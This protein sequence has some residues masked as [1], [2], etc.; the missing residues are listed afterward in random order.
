MSQAVSSFTGT[1][2]DAGTIGDGIAKIAA[3]VGRTFHGSAMLPVWL[4]HASFQC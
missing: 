1:A 2:I 4:Q 3:P